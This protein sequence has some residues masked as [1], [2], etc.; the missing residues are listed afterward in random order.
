[1][2]RTGPQKRVSG[3]AGI[4]VPLGSDRPTNP[5]L[6][7]M[8]ARLDPNR[9]SEAITREQAVIAYTFT[10]AYAESAEK[11]TG[12]L[13]PGKRA[14][15]AVLSQDIFK[16]DASALLKTESLLTLVGGKIVY[17]GKVTAHEQSK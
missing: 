12:N 5:Y 4:P 1:V 11:V 2:D 3:Y 7:I 8:F 14:D 13:E 17:D 16:V 15:L 9:S 10:S 6:N